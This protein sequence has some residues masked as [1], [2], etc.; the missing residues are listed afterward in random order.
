MIQV[1]RSNELRSVKQLE[2]MSANLSEKFGDY[3][4]VVVYAAHL[5]G[6]LI[7]EYRIWL[8]S[9]N[10]I[11]QFKTWRECQDKYFELMQEP[12]AVEAVKEEIREYI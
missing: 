4:S 5:Q 3:C 9:L 12:E 11:H 7:Q 8:G 1:N 2:K 6:K 10:F